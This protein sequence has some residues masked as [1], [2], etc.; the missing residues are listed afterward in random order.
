MFPHYQPSKASRLISSV[1]G[2]LQY[3]VTFSSLSSPFCSP[4][5]LTIIS[6]SPAVPSPHGSKLWPFFKAR[7][8][9]Y[10]SFFFFFPMVTPA[11]Y[12]GFQVKGQIG[13][14]AASLC[15]SHSNTGSKPHLWPTTQLV[16]TPDPHGQIL[17]VT[18]LTHWATMRTPVL[19]VLRSFPCFLKHS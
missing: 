8:K 5:A 17:Y 13:A 1:C 15:H 9:C 7:D 10:L 11:A 12:G 14:T 3:G 19:L 16:A 4:T 6:S 18:F 2:S